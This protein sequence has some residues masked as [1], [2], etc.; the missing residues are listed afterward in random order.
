VTLAAVRAIDPSAADPEAPRS[1]GWLAVGWPAIGVLGALVV[2]AAALR[3][4]RIGTAYWIDEALS[5]GIA[6]HAITDIPSLL[7]RD[8]SPPLWYLLMH[9]WT[10]MFGTSVEATHALS[11]LWSLLVVPA[12]WFAGRRLFDER[13][14]WFAAAMATISPFITYFSHETRMYSLVVLLGLVVATTFVAAFVDGERRMIWWF[15]G[16]LLL[17]LYTHNWGLYTAVAC[18]IALGALVILSDDRPALLRRGAIAFGLVGAGYLPW[19]P[20][21]LSQVQNTGA[22]WS[23][24]PS[25]RQVVRELAALFRDERI[26]VALVLAT[27]VGLGPLARRWRSRDALAVGSLAVLALVPIGIGWVLAHLEP[28]WATRYLAVIVGPLLLIIGLGLA[29][30]RGLGVAAIAVTALLILQPLTRLQGLELPRDAKSNATTLAEQM[31][32]RLD[33]GDLVIVAQPEAVPLFRSVLGPVLRYA[34]PTGTIEDATVMDWRDA[35]DRLRAATLA[36]VL[37]LVEELRPGQRL[38][39]VRPG[40]EARTTDT[41]WIQLFRARGRRITEALRAD[42]RF[43]V[44]DRLRGDDAPYVTF[45]AILYERV[46]RAGS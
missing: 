27:G 4:E 28:S 8:G 26:L 22:P 9:G 15:A 45:D 44:V 36:D 34:D 40:N 14:G 11:L 17:L 46:T 12:A 16:S 25:L 20:V 7:L 21:L 3:L 35:E 24:T 23:Y 29:R 5:L 31:A 10:A 42:Q 1:H 33:R 41:P 37:P 2:L 13:A 6:R 32:P 43:A 39:V 30:A 19:V 38:L 18:G